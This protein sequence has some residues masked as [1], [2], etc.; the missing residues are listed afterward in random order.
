MASKGF[1]TERGTEHR[2]TD[3]YYKYQNGTAETVNRTIVECARTM[4]DAL[5]CGFRQ[6]VLGSGNRARR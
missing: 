6:C 5:V 3:P 4:L 1:L 2:V